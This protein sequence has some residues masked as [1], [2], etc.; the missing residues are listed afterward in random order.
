[1]AA[2]LP[3]SQTTVPEWTDA[4]GHTIRPGDRV[5]VATGCKSELAV[6]FG[7]LERIN[8]HDSYGNRLTEKEVRVVPRPGPEAD[9]L[10]KD[11]EWE[12]EPNHWYDQRGEAVFTCYKQAVKYTWVPEGSSYKKTAKF[13]ALVR[14]D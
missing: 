10:G 12:Y 11:P 14:I 2:K 9:A 4:A 13:R 7:I 5:A 1:M 6:E 3:L 8:T